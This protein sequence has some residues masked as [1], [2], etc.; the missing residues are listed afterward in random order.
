MKSK[1]TIFPKMPSSSQ[2]P[3][4]SFLFISP[5]PPFPL[6]PF[7]PSFQIRYHPTPTTNPF[8]LSQRWFLN[9]PS[10]YRSPTQFLPER[11]LGPSP[12]PP[13][14]K[15]GAFGYGRRVCTGRALAEQTGWLLIAQTLSVFRV[16][17]AGAADKLRAEQVMG[18]GGIIHHPPPFDMR[19]EVRGE[20][21]SEVLEKAGGG[22]SWEEG[23]SRFVDVVLPPVS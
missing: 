3:G 12:E 10:T 13:P 18:T 15:M 4:K 16:L 22:L 1:A 7:R 21:A 23:D 11:F 8:A 20:E 9:D 19:I 6:P 2:I 14:D 5:K 17:P